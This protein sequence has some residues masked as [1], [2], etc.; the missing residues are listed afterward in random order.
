M[1]RVDKS[2]LLFRSRGKRQ[3]RWVDSNGFGRVVGLV[4]SNKTICKLKHVVSQTDDHKLSILGSFLDVIRDNGDVSEI[5]GRINFIHYIQR[6]GLEVMQSK[7]KSQRTQS[8]SYFMN[9]VSYKE[10]DM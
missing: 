8:L 5:Q 10:P 9:G 1:G 2:V 7:H 4:D 6:R 3:G